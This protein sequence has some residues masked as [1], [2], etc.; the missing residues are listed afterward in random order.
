MDD[1]PKVPLRRRALLAGTVALPLTF[2][3]G[4]EAAPLAR[5][6]YDDQS[7]S[8]PPTTDPVR[9]ASVAGLP[10][11]ISLAAAQAKWDAV[12]ADPNVAPEVLTEALSDLR[13]AQHAANYPQA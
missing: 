8:R 9:A 13:K 12:K 7:S 2:V 1:K 11:T 10:G 6:A 3:A 5:F 4:A